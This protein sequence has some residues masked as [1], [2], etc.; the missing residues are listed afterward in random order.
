MRKHLDL[1]KAIRDAIR[2]KAQE[3]SKFKQ[4]GNGA[5]R[6]LFYPLCEEADEW[7]GGLSSFSHSNTSE[8]SK[9]DIVDYEY[10]FAIT[11]GGS[12][13]IT[14]Q[15]KNNAKIPQTIDC[16]AYSAMKIAHCS[17]VQDETSWLVSGLN[18]ENPYLTEEYGYAAR[19][20]AICIEIYKKANLDKKYQSE[21]Y[22]PFCNVYICVSGASE[23][24]D[25]DC[26]KVAINVVEQ[27]FKK[28]GQQQFIF[29][30]P[31]LPIIY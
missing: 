18:L 16:Y 20:G 21:K 5:I 10:V 13:V 15:G 23:K 25:Y 31:D 28:K 17:R 7:L 27:F 8:A 22:E 24:E 12:R 1:V 29:K 2:K 30:V 9:N 11:K 4:T 6:I 26:A 19:L 14:E 3:I